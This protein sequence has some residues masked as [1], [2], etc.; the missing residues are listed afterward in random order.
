MSDKDIVGDNAKRRTIRLPAG[1][2]GARRP[3]GLWPR[4]QRWARRI[5]LIAKLEFFLMLMAVVMG[6]ITYTALSPEGRPLDTGSGARVSLTLLLILTLL[7]ILGLA[8]LI[9]R[10]VVILWAERRKNSAGSRLHGRVII[11]FSLVAIVPTLLVAI[12]SSLLFEFGLRVWFSDRVRTVLDSAATV[13]EAYVAEHRKFL[14]E[15]IR[16]FADDLNRG[17]AIYEQNPSAL[18]DFVANQL[19]FRDL[20]EAIIFDSSMRVLARASNNVSIG[21]DGVARGDFERALAGDVVIITGPAAERDRVRAVIK[22]SKFFDSYLYVSRLVDPKVLSHFYE[23]QQAVS[24]YRQL[25]SERSTTQLRFNIVLVLVSLAILLAA[26]VAGFSFA[27]RLV[28][29]LSHLLNASERVRKGDLTARV[30]LRGAIDEIGVLARAF[31]RMTGQLQS[32]TNE[33]VAANQQLDQRSRFTEAVLGGVSAGVLGLDAEG[34]VNL[35]NRSACTLL[36]MPAQAMA[37]KSLDELAPEMAGLL[38]LAREDADGH[39]EGQVNL[40]RDGLFRNLL[41]QVRAERT[42]GTLVGYVVTFDDITGQLADQRRAAWADVARRIAH[43]IKNPLTPIQLS[44]ERLRRKYAH[45]VTSDPAVFEQCTDTI[46]RQ[47][48]DLRRMVDEFSSFARMP[49]PIF[50]REDFIDVVR[51]AAFLLEVAHSEIKFELQAPQGGADLV[52][53]RRLIAQAVTNL[54]KNAAE[55]IEQRRHDSAETAF[56]GEVRIAIDATDRQIS[57]T[58]EDN[59]RG[60]PPEI[61]ERLFE[62]YVTTRAKGTGLGLAIVK[63]IVEDHGGRLSLEDREAGGARAIIHF[64]RQHLAERLAEAQSDLGTAAE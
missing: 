56:K 17:A 11:L 44:A 25:E 28:R 38:A 15:E 58:V 22:L 21:T 1:Q 41:V 64:D 6:I 4:I 48:N 43:E 13:A 34:R 31:N 53:D 16:T 55:S 37:G 54:V 9:A 59:G 8:A 32:Q 51:H 45:E 19:V 29:P 61:R 33:L 7:P 49:A 50:H 42:Q 40:D 23:T 20:S 18:Q 3:I 2:L 62:P 36:R 30:P 39:A 47:V 12:F 5:D 52:C 35:P 10:R 24:E 46:I 63:K 57:L 60:L 27:T 14:G 26:I